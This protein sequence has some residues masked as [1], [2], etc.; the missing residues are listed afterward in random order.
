MKALALKGI[1]VSHFTSNITRKSH[2]SLTL[3]SKLLDSFANEQRLKG[4][5]QDLH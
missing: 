1:P 2:V 3:R 4:I 5:L